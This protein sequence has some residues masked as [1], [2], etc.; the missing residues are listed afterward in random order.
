MTET[1]FKRVGICIK[2]LRDRSP[3]AIFHLIDFL[4]KRGVD[5]C[6]DTACAEA[7]GRED[8]PVFADRIP[9]GVDLIIVLGGDGTMLSVVRMVGEREIPIL[10]INFG[11]LGFLTEVPR[12]HMLPMLESIFSGRFR[13]E[14]RMQII[15]D[16]RRKGQEVDS[17]HALNDAVINK[18][19]LARII[20]LEVFVD[21]LFL[22]I[23]KSDGLIVS[24]PTGSTAYSLSA[25]GP[26]LVPTQ[27]GL[28]IAPI[29]P[30]TLTHRPLVL[31]GGSTIRI[32]FEAGEAVML[33]VDGQTGLEL[34]HNDEILIRRSAR[35]ARLVF[36]REQNFFQ[37]LRQKLKWGERE[38]NSVSS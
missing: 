2:P 21:D 13:I 23:Y 9:V 24:T 32:R 19:A 8:L 33:T 12:E 35:V 16:V 27:Q 37:V 6:L 1:P 36:P 15:V 10:G 22:S 7:T 3:E 14:C 17:F 26:I 5:V 20:D 38:G 31:D 29:C 18:G 34:H 25:G 30:H 4:Q 11:S 28:I